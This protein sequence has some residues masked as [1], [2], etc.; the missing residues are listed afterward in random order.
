VRLSQGTRLGPYE[1]LSPLGAGGMGEV[2]RARDAAL[3]R[4]VALKVLPSEFGADPDRLARFKREAQVLASLNHPNIAHIHG[5]EKSDATL[6]LVMELVEGPTLAERLAARPIPLEDALAIARQIAEALEAAHDQGIVHRD[7]KPA[8]VKVR[9]DGTVKVLDFGLAK[10]ADAANSSVVNAT[11]SPTLSMRATQAGLI[12]GTAAYMSPEQAAG[13]PTD[14]RTDI[15]SF[16]VVLWEMLTGTQLFNGETIS[17]TLADVLRAEIDFG[18][19]PATIPPSIRELVKR[20][21]DRDIKTRLRDI[22]EARV[23]IQRWLADP[24]S[25]SD[26]PSRSAS[27]SRVAAA[28]WVAAAALLVI[29]IGISFV[30]FRETPAQ[31]PELGRFVISAPDKTSFHGSAVVSPD[32]R[33]IVFVAGGAD[34][35]RLW[36]RPLDLLESRVLAGTEGVTGRPFW[37]A[38][39]RQVVFS[40]PGRLKKVDVTGGP[41]QTIC[42]LTST[43]FG[44]FWTRDDQIVFGGPPGL[45][46]VAA[47]GGSHAPVTVPDHTRGEQGHVNPSLLPDGRHF[48][49]TRFAPGSDAAGVYLGSLD[50]RPDQQG[51]TRLLPDY[52]HSAYV[53]A[54]T[55][56]SSG[57]LLFVRE[58]TLMARPFDAARRQFDGE[59]VPV[60]AQLGKVIQN[61]VPDFSVSSTGVLVYRTAATSS[62]QLTWYD[63]QGKAIATVWN[64]GAYGDVA[65]SPD[66]SRVSVSVGQ[67]AES[68]IWTFDFASQRS[69]R[70]TSNPG[71]DYAPV[72]SP[73]GA[74]LL[75][76]SGRGSGANFSIKTANGAGT[77]QQLLTFDY[78]TVAPTDWSRDGRFV[79][80]AN[81][82]DP[83][84]LGDLWLLDMNGE[85]K[86]T[87]FLGTQ[88]DEG[89]AKFSPDGRY[90]AYVSDES[91]HLEVYVVTFPDPNQGKWPISNG[92]G[93]QPR[94]RRDGKE[95]LY[96]AGDPSTPTLMSVEVTLV[97][98]FKAAVPV[99]MFQAP[100]FSTGSS[101]YRW[102]MT[103][104]G[105][106]FL[107]N[108]AAGEPN[109]PITVVLNWQEE[110][111]RRSTK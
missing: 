83:N 11:M 14:K 43:A 54:R 18:K 13:K 29:V 62:R 16:G 96:L 6:A 111:K 51:S 107:I 38:D 27:S 92:G 52:Y 5:L 7:L 60:A 15:W 90:V 110:L 100:T 17:H 108:A 35:D 28:G 19:L 67:S 81:R 79:I 24:V 46:V 66:D 63:R 39:S 42:D 95:L 41:A 30:H 87:K 77:E 55:G 64:P 76:A 59:A 32:G 72:W 1:I 109:G 21:L 8:N 88:F 97:P 71:S 9:E 37:S 31:S 50:A 105:R 65:M 82:N 49:Y 56:S 68:D 25:G 99:V 70:I 86:P 44:G 102:D 93:Y 26:A 22:G 69:A 58:T 94:W 73:D 48:V 45:R 4:D 80:Y 91:G 106:R 61:I 20:C 47:G 98:S 103:R 12:L 23:A 2:Y 84:Q 53:P 101:V 34:G 85:R 78:R 40:V 57:F 10:A 36:V 89:S 74:K 104:D 3:N 33:Y 75:W